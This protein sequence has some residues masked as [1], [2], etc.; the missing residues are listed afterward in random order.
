[1][2][3]LTS[4]F[5]GHLLIFNWMTWFCY[6]FKKKSIYSLLDE[7]EKNLFFEVSLHFLDYFFG[8]TKDFSLGFVNIC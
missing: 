7:S 3:L 8:I 4:V 1:M 2:F 6:F 5:L